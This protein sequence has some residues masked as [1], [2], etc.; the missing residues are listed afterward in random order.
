MAL[1][2]RSTAWLG[3]WNR[4]GLNFKTQELEVNYAGLVSIS[5]AMTWSGYWE[6]E[7][8]GFARV[9]IDYVRYRDGSQETFFLEPTLF[10]SNVSRVGWRCE[11]AHARVRGTITIDHWG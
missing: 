6:E 2:G 5:T 4:Y 8:S 11:V 10:R 1:T 9:G 3:C 7:G